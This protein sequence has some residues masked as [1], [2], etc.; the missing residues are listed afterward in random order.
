MAILLVPMLAGGL[1]TIAARR[2]FDRDAARALE[3]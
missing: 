2:F 1:L 3:A